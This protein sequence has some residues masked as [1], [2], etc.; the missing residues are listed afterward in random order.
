MAISFA[1]L[2]VVQTGLLPNV[3]RDS[4]TSLERVVS[5]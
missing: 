5:P 3:A 2:V 4:G 1:V